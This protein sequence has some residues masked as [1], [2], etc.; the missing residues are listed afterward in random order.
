[1]GRPYLYPKAVTVMEKRFSLPPISSRM[2]LCSMAVVS[3]VVF[4]MK[5]A[6]SRTGE[7]A[8]TSRRTASSIVPPGS[9]RGW[10]RREPL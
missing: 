5:S 7:R 10:G 9:C 8:L 4:I 3:P 2:R 1:M 6:R